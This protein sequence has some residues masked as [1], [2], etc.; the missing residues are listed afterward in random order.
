MILAPQIGAGVKD[1]NNGFT[2]L[3]MGTAKDPAIALPEQSGAATNYD[4]GLFGY[5]SGVRTIFLD[6]KTGK[7]VF[8]A[9]G[10]G[11][12]MLDPTNSTAKIQSGNYPTTS[13]VAT[14]T[15][16]LIDFTTPEIR[17][18]S[19]NFV[20][21]SSGRLTATNADVT[22]TIHATTLILDNKISSDDIDLDIPD[23][24]AY[25]DNN[26]LMRAGQQP[27]TSGRSG[28]TV[29]QAGVLQASNAVIWGGIY[30][31]YGT[32]A[33]FNFSNT[34]NTGTSVNQGHFYTNSLYA[35]SGDGTY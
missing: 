13:G 33:G 4:V 22:G 14:G 3:F 23:I 20:V 16:M 31:S 17:F 2:G 29:S 30:A 19:G 1:P 27:P 24:S 10:A 34:S 11:Q 35:Q 25:F 12:I 7:A 21:D 6:S 32:I 18:G 8:G 15:G 26:G 28:F 5:N 9:Q